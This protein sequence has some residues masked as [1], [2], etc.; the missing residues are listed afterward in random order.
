MTTPTH[1]EKLQEFA[2]GIGCKLTKTRPEWHTVKMK[3]YIHLP[4]GKRVVPTNNLKDVAKLLNGQCK[5]MGI[6]RHYGL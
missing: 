4:D 6:N 2:R 1:Y 3:Y 5:I